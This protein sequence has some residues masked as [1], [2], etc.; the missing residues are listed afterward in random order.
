VDYDVIGVIDGPQV[1]A[2][3]RQSA[4]FC[5]LA[6]LRA[7]RV[8]LGA[9]LVLAPCAFNLQAQISGMTYSRRT[10]D[11]TFAHARVLLSATRA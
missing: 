6:D 4:I 11:P 7:N 9:V 3:R 8:S 1:A 10:V 5:T 2:S